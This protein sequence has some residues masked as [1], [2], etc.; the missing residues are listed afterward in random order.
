MAQ[1]IIV[2]ENIL[3]AYHKISI[4]YHMHL[5]LLKIKMVVY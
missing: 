2:I 1:F 5:K 4:L 3:I